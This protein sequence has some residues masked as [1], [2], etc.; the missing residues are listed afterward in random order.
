MGTAHLAFAGER[1]GAVTSP[2]MTGSCITGSEVT[3]N[4]V[5]RTGTGIERNINSRGFPP[6]FPPFFQELL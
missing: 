6:Y 1:W 4:H 5:T 3:G 2:E